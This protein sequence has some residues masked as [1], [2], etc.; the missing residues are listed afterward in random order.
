MGKI[1]RSISG[2]RTRNSLRSF[3]GLA[4][5]ALVGITGLSIS[6]ATATPFA[7]TSAGA[8]AAPWTV[9]ASYPPT[10]A[11]LSDTACPSAT[12]CFA[13]GYLDEPNGEGDLNGGVILETNNGGATWVNQTVPPVMASGT[14]SGIQSIACPSTSDC[15]AV[16]TANYGGVILGTTDGG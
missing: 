8:I 10:Q 3:L 12:E 2:L 1:G 6:V 4:M 5:A 7:L 14:W 16:G 13:V 9:L 11:D 15:F